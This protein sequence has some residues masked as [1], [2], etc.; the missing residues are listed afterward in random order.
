M[1]DTSN[2]ADTTTD[3]A[4]PTTAP[5]VAASVKPETWEQEAWDVLEG[6]EQDVVA[7]LHAAGQV[8]TADVWP[9]IKTAIVTLLTQEGKAICSAVVGSITDPSA[10]PEVVGAAIVVTAT[11]DAPAD[12]LNAVSAAQNAVAADPAAQAIL[13]PAS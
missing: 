7:D 4:T 3:T 10:L 12:A 11:K 1:S 5:V 2:A 9:A 8:F 13:N 6:W